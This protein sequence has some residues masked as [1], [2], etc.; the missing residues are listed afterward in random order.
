MA[1]I[2][3]NTTTNAH[4]TQGKAPATLFASAITRVAIRATAPTLVAILSAVAV[5]VVF[6]VSSTTL[7]PNAFDPVGERSLLERYAVQ[8]DGPENDAGRDVLFVVEPQ[9]GETISQEA[10]DALYAKIEACELLE[11]KLFGFQYDEYEREPARFLSADELQA[12]AQLAVVAAKL[13][14]NDSKPLE[15]KTIVAQLAQSQDVDAR[16]AFAKAFDDVMRLPNPTHENIARPVPDGVEAREPQAFQTAKFLIAKDGALAVCQ[17]TAQIDPT[18]DDARPLVDA[19]DAIV[20]EFCDEFPGL[21]ATPTGAIPLQNADLAF[22]MNACVPIAIAFLVGAALLAWTTFARLSRAL[23]VLAAI[24]VATIC[25]LGLYALCGA[26]TN[27]NVVFGILALATLALTCAAVYLAQYAAIRDSERSVSAA[28]R[29]TTDVVATPLAFLAVMAC[30]L[31]AAIALCSLELRAAG[32]ALV[33]GAPTTWLAAIALLPALLQVVDGRRPLKEQGSRVDLTQYFAPIIRRPRATLAIAAIAVVACAAAVSNL[34]FQPTRTR[35]LPDRAPTRVALERATNALG[36]NPTLRACVRLD[37]TE[38]ARA[39]KGRLE[40][41]QTLVVFDPT[42]AA[43]TSGPDRE[44]KIAAIRDALNSLQTN[45][46]EL[47]PPTYDELDEPLQALAD[48][49]KE[50]DAGA[51]LL[52]AIERAALLE[53]QERDARLAILQ[54]VFAVETLKRLFTLRDLVER[55]ADGQNAR[56]KGVE[57]TVY[58]TA[59]LERVANLAAFVENLVATNPKTTGPAPRALQR[60]QTTNLLRVVAAVLAFLAIFAVAAARARSALTAFAVLA[61][62]VAVYLA[63]LG[64]AAWLKTPLSVET[65]ALSVLAF[66]LAADAARRVDANDRAT[67]AAP[68]VAITLAVAFCPALAQTEQGWRDFARLGILVA[69]LYFVAVAILIPA[70][71]KLVEEPTL[72]IESPN[73]ENPLKTQQ[74]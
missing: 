12:A 35:F 9:S 59:D 42:A 71:L 48:V 31:G 29:A 68:I 1:I 5:A 39:L 18:R 10:L 56:A 53:P 25:S 34:Q 50:E 13:A 52:D 73:S 37:S 11:P 2:M 32:L 24:L 21:D 27:P 16:F 36:F 63:L 26:P 61:P 47:A 40:E 38:D 23:I 14:R 49:A 64:L 69:A 58:S 54:R 15:L 60:L 19:V 72:E 17:A 33:I 67:A 43:P 20:N 3:N 57:L 45:L 44:M 28:L 7:R 22:A 55:R 8:I 74:N 66:L 4:E 51:T 70:A 62:C 30:A 41:D 65:L 6:I 46:P